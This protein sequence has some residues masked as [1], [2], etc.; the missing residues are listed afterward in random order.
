ME[1]WFERKY[2]DPYNN[3]VLPIVLYLTLPP[4]YNQHDSFRNSQNI[5]RTRSKKKQQRD[6]DRL[7]TFRERKTVCSLFPFSS[8]DDDEFHDL[9]KRPIL[10][11]IQCSENCKTK[12]EELQVENDLWGLNYGDLQDNF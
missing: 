6:Q 9:M 4:F 8:V 1:H 12:L 2:Y 3:A 7:D 10:V 11:H 5:K